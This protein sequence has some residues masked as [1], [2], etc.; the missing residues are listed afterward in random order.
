MQ[1]EASAALEQT[2]RLTTT[3]EELLALARTGR[4]GIVGEFDLADLVRKH[5]ADAEDV[6]SRT[7]RRIVVD[8]DTPAPV[9]AAVGALGQVLDIV[10]SN[11]TRHGRGTVTVRVTNDERHAAVEIGDEGPGLDRDDPLSA[12]REHPDDHGHGIGLAFGARRS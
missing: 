9:V 8:A 6:L 11:A 1:A 5:A 3:V 7:G 12:F 2:E 4:A 10:L